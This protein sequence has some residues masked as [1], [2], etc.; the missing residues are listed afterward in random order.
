MCTKSIYFVSRAECFVNNKVLLTMHEVW[1]GMGR[2]T[3]LRTKPLLQLGYFAGG[4]LGSY[5]P[6]HL[7]RRNLSQIWMKIPS[8][9]FI[10]TWMSLPEFSVQLFDHQPACGV[11][12][13]L[14]RVKNRLPVLNKR[15]S[16]IFRREMLYDRIPHDRIPLG[17]ARNCLFSRAHE[18]HVVLNC[19]T[20]VYSA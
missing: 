18:A 14:G 5:S 2:L 12:P 11:L 4:L 16:A 1:G 20:C 19:F 10:I 15:L 3:A 7:V 8:V 9:H 17:L 6:R 13:H